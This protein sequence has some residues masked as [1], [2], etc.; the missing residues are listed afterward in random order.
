M[1]KFC[2]IFQHSFYIGFCLVLAVNMEN[3]SILSWNLYSQCSQLISAPTVSETVANRFTWYFLSSIPYSPIFSLFPTSATWICQPFQ[4]CQETPWPTSFSVESGIKNSHFL[5]F[6]WCNFNRQSVATLSLLNPA[7]LEVGVEHRCWHHR[8]Q[9][10]QS[11]CPTSRLL[12]STAGI[13][14]PPPLEKTGI[15]ATEAQLLRIYKIPTF[16]GWGNNERP[17][18]MHSYEYKWKK[19]IMYLFI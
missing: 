12:G 7:N 4:Q 18:R 14:L 19:Y 5:L 2:L 15:A 9:E 11:P 16:L 13:Q 3:T 8:Q 10:Q 17:K 6:H 1:N